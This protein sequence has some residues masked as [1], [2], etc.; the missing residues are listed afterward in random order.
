MKRI[1]GNKK[2]GKEMLKELMIILLTLI[3]SLLVFKNWDSIKAF[4]VSI[5]R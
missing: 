5:F 3:V 4:I 2:T 1:S